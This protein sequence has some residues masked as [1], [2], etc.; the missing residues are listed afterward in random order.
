MRTLRVFSQAS[1]MSDDLGTAF[2]EMLPW[3]QS[4]DDLACAVQRSLDRTDDDE[5]ARA[6]GK[7][8]ETAR[9]FLGEADEH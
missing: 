1:S 5:L 4:V 6:L 9:A 7:Y 3:L 8:H 2:I